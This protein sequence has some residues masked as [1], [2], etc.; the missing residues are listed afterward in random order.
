[1][2]DLGEGR[3]PSDPRIHSFD[4]DGTHFAFSR[5]SDYVLEAR[6]CMEASSTDADLMR[7]ADFLQPEVFGD[8]SAAAPGP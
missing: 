6:A 5:L 2:L 3:P 7:W 4:S 1:M 8:V